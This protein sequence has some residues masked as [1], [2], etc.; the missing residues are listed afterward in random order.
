MKNNIGQRWLWNCSTDNVKIKFI[1]EIIS[2]KDM[3]I[4]K[5][6][7][8]I[9]N[10]GKPQGWLYLGIKINYVYTLDLSSWKYLENQDKI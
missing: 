5:I 1:A 9:G 6:L 7:K 4:I 8:N 3:E 10:D 2:D